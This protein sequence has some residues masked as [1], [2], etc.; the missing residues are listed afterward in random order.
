MT[1]HPWLV[2]Q[3]GMSPGWF[4]VLTAIG[5]VLVAVGVVDSQWGA[6]AGGVAAILVGGF[7]TMRRLYDGFSA[8]GGAWV[9]VNAGIVAGAVGII[10]G[11]GLHGVAVWIVVIVVV[12]FSDWIATAVTGERVR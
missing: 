7:L 9:V 11:L 2:Q 1:S 3:R 10:V 4:N 5:F 8:R 12:F 6:V